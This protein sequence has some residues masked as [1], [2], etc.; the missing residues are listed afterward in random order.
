MKVCTD[1]CIFGAWVAEKIAAGIIDPKNILDIGCG[2]GLLTLMLA[3]K[4]TSFI[5]AVEIDED[6]YLQATEN[7][8]D[9]LWV[10]RINIYHTSILDFAAVKK[11]DLIISNPPFYEHDL[12]SNDEGRNK[13]MHNEGLSFEGLSKA[14]SKNLSEKGSA[15]LL[16]PFH[17]VPDLEKN[18]TGTGLFIQEKIN[19]SHSPTHV[20]FR[21]MLIIGFDDKALAE[22]NMLIRNESNF[23]SDEFKYLLRDYYLE[24]N[25]LKS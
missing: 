23:Y 17:R 18:L 24:Q 16:L 14:I 3:Q 10:K 25:F 20:P 19:V 15:V 5:D 11:Y 1:A 7:I 6:A 22:N 8:N 13:A 21:S 2:T 12:K 9:S 4:T